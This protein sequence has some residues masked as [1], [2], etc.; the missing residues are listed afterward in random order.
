MIL[1]DKASVSQRMWRNSEAL[2][3]ERALSMPLLFSPHISS[4]ADEE[5]QT[6]TL[7]EPVLRRKVQC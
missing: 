2:D 3:Q 6:P 4:D 5:V 1:I 7:D